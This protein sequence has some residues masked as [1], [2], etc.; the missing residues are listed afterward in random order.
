[1]GEVY[2]ARDTKLNRG[3][4]LV[5]RFVLVSAC[6]AVCQ[7][8]GPDALQA[9][10]AGSAPVACANPT[11]EALRLPPFVPD[12]APSDGPYGRLVP[13][14]T[15]LPLG[16]G[17]LRSFTEEHYWEWHRHVRLPLFREP[18]QDIP[19][20]WIADGWLI[21][22]GDETVRPFGTA[23]LVETEYESSSLI[24]YETRPDGWVHFRY[25]PEENGTAWTHECFFDLTDASVSL[26]TWEERLTNDQISPLFFRNEVPHAVRAQPQLDSERLRWLPATT[27]AYHLEPLEVQ[28]DW[29]R[30]R[31][32]QPSDYCS[33]PGG[34][35]TRRFDGW[36]RWRDDNIGPW[37]WYYTRG[38]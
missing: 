35:L 7:G 37:L 18:G 34:P 16:L 11:H 24:V 8:I 20:G 19:F 30:V 25:L 32:V 23:G 27:D 36:V 33:G 1:M 21:D 10:Q 29:M 14:N 4:T 31:V 26:T 5:G 12:S 15:G 2:R 3:Q 38:C 9:L 17:F 22:L 13:H 6:A 28:G